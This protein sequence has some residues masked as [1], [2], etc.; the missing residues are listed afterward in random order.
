MTNRFY[1]VCHLPS[2]SSV[3]LK[4]YWSPFWLRK[5]GK[6]FLNQLVPSVDDRRR[7]EATP[8]CSTHL[9]SGSPWS[10]VKDSCPRTDTASL[11]PEN[12]N[13]RPW[14]LFNEVIPKIQAH[15][16]S[17]WNKSWNEQGRCVSD[18]HTTGTMSM[19]KCGAFQPSPNTERNSGSEEGWEN[20]VV[21]R[22]GNET[23]D[24]Q[25]QSGSILPFLTIKL[26]CMCTGRVA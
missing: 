15:T 14:V 16:A 4:E 18:Q 10:L 22:F 7:A 25:N 13:K 21:L 26:A 8:V 2:P 9:R 1:F 6:T 23:Q 5:K 24:S 19:G 11:Q 12:Q 17:L 3:F 20:P